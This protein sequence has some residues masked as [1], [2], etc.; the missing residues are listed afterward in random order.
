MEGRAGGSVCGIRP[1]FRVSPRI[2]M[3][4]RA[5]PC[6]A[7]YHYISPCITTRHHISP[8]YHLLSGGREP[9]L[10]LFVPLTCM[11]SLSEPASHLHAIT[12]HLTCMPSRSQ[13][14]AC[15]HSATQPPSHPLIHPPT[16]PLIHPLPT[17]RPRPLLP[18]HTHTL[19]ACLHPLPP[20]YV[21][22]RACLTGAVKS[23]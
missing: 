2:T 9:V 4:H 10:T 21:S 3:Y 18:T 8:Q 6:V 11:P 13:P 20:L 1:V 23:H 14:P 5:S 7:T 17:Q 15:H 16:H 12:A 22:M 19:H